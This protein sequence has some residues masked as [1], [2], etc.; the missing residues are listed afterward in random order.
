[1]PSIC[2][3]NPASGALIAE[4]PDWGWQQIEP[5]IG[6]ADQAYRQWSQYRIEQ[7]GERFMRLA[8]LLLEQ[9]AEL[10]HL[11]AQEM[12]KPLRQGIAEIE[13]CAW[14]CRHYAEHSRGYLQTRS[15]DTGAQQSLVCFQPLGIIFLVMP[16]NFPF[17]QVFRAA[18]P[19]MM[20]GNAIL[21]KHASNVFGCA[22]AIERLFQQ[23]AFPENSF[24]TLLTGSH[25]AAQILAHR[26]VRGVSLTGSEGAG[27]AVAM[28][29]ARNLK[30][31]V[32]ELGGSDPY[33][34]LEDADLDAT[35]SSC[36][37][38]RMLNGG[39]VCIAAKRFIVVEAVREEFE[40]KL[41]AQMGSYVMGDPLDAATNFG[42]MAKA[43]LR[44][45][46]HQQVLRSIEQGAKLRLGGVVPPQA[47]AWYPPTILS[48]VTPG[49]AAF[50]EELF[51]PVSVIV[52]ARDELH[53]IELANQTR[54]GLGAAVFTQDIDKG[55]RIARDQLEAGATAV[56][57]FVKSDPRLPFGG[58]KD[59]GYGREIGEFGILEFVNIKTVVI[60]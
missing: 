26:A 1:M 14:V 28:E 57:G 47:G 51:G 50:D 30:K 58:I 35:V 5:I 29:A 40:R 25:S 46:L 34:V 37:T 53:A 36:A 33:V 49:M 18:V 39:Q 17:W 15:I 21:L 45:E 9:K 12:G 38:A 44:D 55:R 48:D 52:T 22:L 19:A 10:A 59:S 43:S 8:G 7:R 16:W 32:L 24:R 56:N 4:Y 13:K 31:S 11:M 20:A 23:A 3:I 41:L 42:P 2:S 6:K 54:F 27:R 60:G